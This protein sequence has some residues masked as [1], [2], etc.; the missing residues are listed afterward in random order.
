MKKFTVISFL[1]GALA[2]VVF[3]HA[4]SGHLHDKDGGHS[5]HGHSHGLINSDTVKTK[6][7]SMLM[8]L[9]K[10]GI[11]DKSW[12]GAK[13][14]NAEKKAFTKGS[15]WVVSFENDKMR[16]KEKQTLYIFY[17]LDGHYIAAN[18]TGK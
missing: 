5:K 9:I 15:E 3:A 6:A 4:G 2:F 11:I 8:G 7:M 16:D 13:P 12:E 17:S 14:A 1:F 10:K 18:Y